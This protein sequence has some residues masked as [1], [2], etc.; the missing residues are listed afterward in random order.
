[1]QDE[2]SYFCD[3]C[4]EEVAIPVDHSA[5]A[6][7][8]FVEDCPVCCNPNVVHVEIFEDGD[9]RVWAEKE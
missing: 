8:E 9:L 7:Q 4:G 6:V 1:M 5:G 3:A 2:S